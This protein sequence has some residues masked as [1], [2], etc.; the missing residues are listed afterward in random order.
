MPLLVDVIAR[1]IP[2]RTDDHQVTCFYNVVGSGIT[3]PAVGARLYQLAREPGVG[4]EIP[5]EWFLQDIRD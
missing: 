3:F 4:Q 5:T 2:G 1:N